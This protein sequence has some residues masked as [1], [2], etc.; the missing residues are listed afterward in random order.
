VT[1]LPFGGCGECRA[2]TSGD[3]FRCDQLQI[4]AGGFG[5]YT[6]IQ[7]RFGLRLPDNLS[8]SEGALIEPLASAYHGVRSAGCRSDSRILVLG[9]GTIGLGV[10]LWVRHL[11]AARVVVAARRHTGARMALEQGA[12][13]F[14]TEGE[15]LAEEAADVLYGPPDLVFD[16]VGA[17]NTLARAIEL[18]GVGGTV[19]ALGASYR[20]VSILP[21]EAL[22]KEVRIVFSAAYQFSDFEATINTLT[23]GTTRHQGIICEEMSLEQLADRFEALRRDRPSGKIMIDPWR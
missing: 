9:V 1:A 6:L 16:C 8:Y 2:C 13:A 19:V 7:E 20:P 4:L 11:G 12:T 5:E 17:D 3:P 22:Q 10:T 15:D 14:V 23:Q 21:V 18:V